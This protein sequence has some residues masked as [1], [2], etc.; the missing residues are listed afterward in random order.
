MDS[1]LILSE[2]VVSSEEVSDFEH[3]FCAS[4]PAK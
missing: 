1:L 3:R 4:G 2:V